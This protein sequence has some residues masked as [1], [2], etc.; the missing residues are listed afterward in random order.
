[1]NATKDMTYGSL[2]LSWEEQPSNGFTVIRGTDAPVPCS[3]H[4]MTSAGVAPTFR[5][6]RAPRRAIQVPAGIAAAVACALLVAFA[7]VGFTALNARPA[8]VSAALSNA[9]VEHVVVEEGD[10]LWAIATSLGVDGATT[11]EVSDFIRLSNGLET[12]TLQP[13]MVLSGP[14]GR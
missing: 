8:S 7:L 12:A 14:V 11:D 6:A 1:M 10:S 2:A 3:S 9:P 4:V 5:S 13:G